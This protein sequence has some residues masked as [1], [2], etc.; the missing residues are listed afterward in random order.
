MLFWFVL[1]LLGAA[2][3]KFSTARFEQEQKRSKLHKIQK[4]LTQ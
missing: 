3:A 2:L 4:R 1:F